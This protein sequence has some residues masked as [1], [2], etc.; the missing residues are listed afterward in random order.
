MTVVLRLI[1]IGAS[2]AFISAAS[3]DGKFYGPTGVKL[4]L[5]Y[6]RA[7]IAFNGK[8]Q[9]I[10]LESSLEG[11]GARPVGWIVPV[12]AM[13][14]VGALDSGVLGT[15][16]LGLD[17]MSRPVDYR[18][19]IGVA[20]LL[21]GLLVVMNA[22]HWLITRKPMHLTTQLMIAAIVG[23]LALVAIPSYQGIEVRH[24]G[25]AGDYDA[26]VVRAT[27]AGEL[28]GWLNTSGFAHGE[29]D[30]SAFDNYIRRGWM[31]VV[32]TV[33]AVRDDP[34]GAGTRA[35]RPLVLQFPVG[36]PVYPLGLTALSGN[37]VQFQLY[38][39]A[40][41]RMEG[42]DRFEVKF[43][44]RLEGRDRV[45]LGSLIGKAAFAG[46]AS[47]RK[48]AETFVTRLDANLTPEQMREDLTLRRAAADSEYRR[49]VFW[50]P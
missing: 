41:G 42:D 12:P 35:T 15:L 11:A 44:R 32:A 19:E 7:A 27:D 39:F 47:A 43:A 50:G 8:E 46:S 5:P 25:R 26:R 36:Q 14:E 17:R 48:F 22:L 33:A 28:V 18:G 40:A 38:V 24:L 16:F 20:M 13:P 49:R 9:L 30:R 23:I 10:V 6:Q 21:L 45:D 37:A 2:L 29:A 3:A 4:T 1:L 34:A 31:F